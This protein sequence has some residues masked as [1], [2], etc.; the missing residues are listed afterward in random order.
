MFAMAPRHAAAQKLAQGKVPRNI[1]RA[2]ALGRMTAFEKPNSK[3]RGIV[4]GDSL[5]R[6][7]AKTLAQQ[8]GEEIEQ[9]CAPFQFALSTRAGTDCVGHALRA[10]TDEN[11][12]MIIESLDGIGAYD[13]IDRSV[14]LGELLKLQGASAMLPFILLF[15]GQQSKYLWRD[16][17]DNV[18]TILQGDGGDQGDPSMPALFAL[19]LNPALPMGKEKLQQGEQLLAFLDDVYVEVT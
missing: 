18:F 14:M 4:T 11:P 2:I 16:E 9:A 5:R 7:V 15:Y 3:V 1:G 6:L 19:G 13:H 10:I 12:E 17:N 8:F